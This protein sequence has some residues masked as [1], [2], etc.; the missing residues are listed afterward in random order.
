MEIINTTKTDLYNHIT[1]RVKD[2]TSVQSMTILTDE[3][4]GA[5]VHIHY[6][7]NPE[8]LYIYRFT[9]TANLMFTVLS[10]KSAG[11]VANWIKGNSEST[12]KVWEENGDRK[13]A[14]I[15]TKP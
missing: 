14:F 6:K 13:S 1:P 8:A 4:E 9:K 7:S 5:S 11:R 12:Y 15:A 3:S 10:E 2:S